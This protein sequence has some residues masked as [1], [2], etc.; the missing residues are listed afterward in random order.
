[1][2]I[3]RHDTTLRDI[4]A[5]WRAMDATSAAHVLRN[6]VWSDLAGEAPFTAPAEPM[7]GWEDARPEDLSTEE[8]AARVAWTVMTHDPRFA[9]QLGRLVR[10]PFSEDFQEFIYLL[11][12]AAARVGGTYAKH[13]DDH[14][15]ASRQLVAAGAAA[16]LGIDLL[17]D[18]VTEPAPT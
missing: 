10:P 5:R 17:R 6:T 1:V 8:R 2:G 14:P 13:F 9:R 7:S 15:E 11:V 12:C 4:A 18:G 16:A 3:T